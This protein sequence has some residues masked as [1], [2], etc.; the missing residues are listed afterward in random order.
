MY[1]KQVLFHTL[2]KKITTKTSG[3]LDPEVIL[4]IQYVLVT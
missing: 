1:N 4:N 2:F 3:D